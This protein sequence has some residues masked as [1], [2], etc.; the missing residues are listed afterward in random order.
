[1]VFVAQRAF[2]QES[3]NVSSKRT[4]HDE[5]SSHVVVTGKPMI[6]VTDLSF[7]EKVRSHFITYDLHESSS[8]SHS[9]AGDVGSHNISASG[10]A[11]R[12]EHLDTG[13]EET[14]DRGELRKFTADIKGE[15]LKAGLYKLTQGKPWVKKDT[16]SLYDII[17][18]IKEGYYPK[19]DF[20]LFGS[21]N[22]VDFRYESS[23]IQGSNA[24]NYSLSL[25]LV[26][27]FSLINTKTYEVVASFSAM[28][29]GTD[30]K[31][32]NSAGTT[33]VPSKSKAVRELSKSLGEDVAK[34]LA[35]QFAPSTG[36]SLSTES[37]SE[38]VQQEKEITNH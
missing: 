6:A 2:G 31:L 24:V 4:S 22:S 19:A 21:V 25:E 38:S 15:M 5:S 11:E 9:S 17:E 20:V 29:E 13:M 16:D 8:T 28:G 37:R 12:I 36:S 14:I 1:M 3:Q 18:R 35:G 32:V 27:E 7:E 26:A 23:P 10:Q 34:Q 30:A 33:Y